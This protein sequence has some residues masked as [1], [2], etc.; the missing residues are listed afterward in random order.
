MITDSNTI[1]ILEPYGG[2]INIYNPNQDDNLDTGFGNRLFYWL[3]TYYL[4]K[5]LKNKFKLL[6][7][8]PWWPELKI[9]ELPNTST[10]EY[11]FNIFEELDLQWAEQQRKFLYNN[12]KICG[13]ITDSKYDDVI[14]GKN[15]LD[16]NNHWVTYFSYAANYD[17]KFPKIKFKNKV[18]DDYIKPQ[19]KD[20]IGVHY[21]RGNGIEMPVLGETYTD[22]SNN[23]GTVKQEDL[24]IVQWKKD[25]LSDIND[26][27]YI[28]NEYYYKILDKKISDNPNLKIYLSYDIP[29]KYIIDFQIRYQ[30]KIIT[31]ENFIDKVKSE[32]KNDGIIFN[33]WPYDNVIRTMIDFYSLLNCSYFIEH[34]L[35]SWTG[36]IKQSKFLMETKNNLL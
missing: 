21:R 28:P 8:E 5:K 32:L 16:D 15:L 23:T 36:V 25:N 10:F 20:V 2:W 33:D 24:K 6:V 27:V 18:F 31:H 3:S 22:E 17:I 9:I 35:S 4:N 13:L 34:P 19:I 26:T 30:K 11:K 7:E 29:S 14:D 12:N 1:R